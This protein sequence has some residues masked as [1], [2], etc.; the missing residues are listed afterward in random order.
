MSDETRNR[1][2]SARLGAMLNDVFVGVG[3]EALRSIQEGSELTGAPGQPVQSGNLRASWH[4]DFPTTDRAEI[5][6]NVI[7]AE[8]VEEGTGVYGP[9]T[10]RSPVGGFH[11]VKI[12]AAN[13]DRI[14]DHEKRRVMGDR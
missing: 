11:S 14:V 7:Y 5:S 10:L 12:T 8:G 2:T 9:L 4:L 6:T 3:T 13:L 1:D